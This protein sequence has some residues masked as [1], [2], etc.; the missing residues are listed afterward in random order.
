MPWL[1]L[2]TLNHIEM[3]IPK[4][5]YRPSN[6][7]QKKVISSELEKY[8]WIDP[9]GN[10][11]VSVSCNALHKETAFPNDMSDQYNR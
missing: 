4:N 5:W 8:F 9:A 3:K 1:L 7:W 10:Q 6:R 11:S 2:L